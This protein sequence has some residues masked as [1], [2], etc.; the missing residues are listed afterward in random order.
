MKSAIKTV[1]TLG[2]AAVIGL[3]GA[4]VVPAEAQN[5]QGNTQ[6]NNVARMLSH[7][8]DGGERIYHVSCRDRSEGN[9]KVIVESNQ[10]CAAPARGQQLCSKDW[11]L[12]DA[13]QYVC[14][15]R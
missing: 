9:V 11:T 10:I 7:G 8:S 13:G 1:S 3:A 2:C 12:R 14:S 15:G 5:N 4:L 6:G